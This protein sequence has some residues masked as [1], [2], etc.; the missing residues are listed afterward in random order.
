MSTRRIRLRLVS[1]AVGKIERKYKQ[2]L[3][4][5]KNSKRD[6]LNKN[7]DIIRYKFGFTSVYPANTMYLKTKY[8]MEKYG[9]ILHAPSLSQ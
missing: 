4:F 6:K 1:I 5:S 9:Y 8:R 3:L 7:I 2:I